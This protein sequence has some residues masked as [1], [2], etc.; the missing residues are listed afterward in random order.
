LIH[1]PTRHGEDLI[2][3]S[4]VD[5]PRVWHEHV[6]RLFAEAGRNERRPPGERAVRHDERV[7]ASHARKRVPGRHCIAQLISV[8]VGWWTDP[9]EQSG[10][11]GED[12]DR[13]TAVPLGELPAEGEERGARKDRW[14]RGRHANAR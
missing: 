9:G 12:T 5:E 2:N 14:V 13:Q 11:I 3:V 1:G 4:M 7:R 8:R 10:G 6:G